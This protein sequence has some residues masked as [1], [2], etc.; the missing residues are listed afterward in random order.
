MYRA[1]VE[2][3]RTL[4]TWKQ[5]NIRVHK[6]EDETGCICDRQANR[7]RK[8][9]K[10]LGCGKGSRCLFCSNPRNRGELPRHE[11]KQMDRERDQL[12]DV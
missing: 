10:I 12:A 5:H 4:K 7:F 9:Q 8:G 11:L 6:G 2:K 3:T 1:A